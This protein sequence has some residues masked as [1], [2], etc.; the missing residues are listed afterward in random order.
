MTEQQKNN[1]LKHVQFLRDNADRIRKD[2]NM[3]RVRHEC[4]SP[5][6]SLGFAY[7][8]IEPREKSESIFGYC[9]RLFGFFPMDVLGK[10]CFSANWFDINNTPEAAAARM[11]AVVYNQV[12]EDWNELEYMLEFSH[13]IV[14]VGIDQ[15]NEIPIQV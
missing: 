3:C 10:Y 4:G 12:P 11:E 7:V 13:P 9:N 6:C 5:A 1:C 15:V 2:F 8:S 14:Q